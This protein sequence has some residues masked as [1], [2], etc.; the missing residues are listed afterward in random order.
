M[1]VRELYE[2]VSQL[3][4]EDSLEN[5][6]RFYYAANRGLLQ[7]NAIRP[8]ISHFVLTHRPIV[9]KVKNASFSVIERTE[10]I[11][12]SATDVKA[13][14]FEAMGVGTVQIIGANDSVFKVIELNSMGKYTAYR[15]FIKDAGSF[16]SGEVKMRFMGEYLYY[17]K[18]V[19][20]YGSLLSADTKDIYPYSAF[21]SYNIGGMVNDFLAFD[22]PPM[23]ADDLSHLAGNYRIEGSQT[24][25]LPHEMA[26]EYRI[27]YKRK[28]RKMSTDYAP[29]D[30][31][32]DVDLDEELCSVLPLIIAS[33]IYAEDEPSLAQF[34]LALYNSRAA[35]LEY[36]TRNYDSVGFKNIY[37][38]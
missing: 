36:K 21:S 5:D 17:I 24:I 25:I 1:Q 22:T 15:G 4:F 28:P 26:G 37:E 29:A 8:A 34:Y 2:Q 7:V 6:K 32:E 18:N 10:D 20:M 30:N 31:N 11:E 3:G 12:F 19:A 35:E 23:D 16:V 13:Y 9:N 27:R 33:Y 38:G 14:Y